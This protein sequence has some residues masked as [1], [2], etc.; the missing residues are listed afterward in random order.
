MV[1]SVLLA[2]S[3]MQV[4]TTPFHVKIL[5][6]V[7][8]PMVPVLMTVAPALPATCALMAILC[9]N[10]VSQAI[11]ARLEKQAFLVLPDIT[12]SSTLCLDRMTASYVLLDLSATQLRYQTRWS[13]PVPQVNTA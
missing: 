13:G 8:P 7:L 12:M 11:T 6:S 1:D 2:T 10:R 3:A 9:L 5:Q 4:H